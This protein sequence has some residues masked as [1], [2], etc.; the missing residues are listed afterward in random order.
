METWIF[1]C[2]AGGVPK[3]RRPGRAAQNLCGHPKEKLSLASSKVSI[4]VPQRRGS[5]RRRNWL[6]HSEVHKTRDRVVL[7]EDTREHMGT[8]IPMLSGVAA[9]VTAD[10]PC[11]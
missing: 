5:P 6:K 3:S 7:I 8:I 1:G 10:S 4:Y 11:G 2:S 9:L